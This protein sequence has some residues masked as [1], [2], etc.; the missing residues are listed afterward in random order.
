LAKLVTTDIEQIESILKG[1]ELEKV[2]ESKM[3]VDQ[4]EEYNASSITDPQVLFKHCLQQVV[5]K[6]WQNLFK[7]R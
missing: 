3:V 2:E 6:K 5:T 4:E 7:V 1:P